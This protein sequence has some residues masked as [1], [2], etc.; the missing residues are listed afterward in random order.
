MVMAVSVSVS[1][2]MSARQDGADQKSQHDRTRESEPLRLHGFLPRRA[3]PG[4][5]AWPEK[6]DLELL[7]PVLFVIAES[8]PT[9]CV[10]CWF[11]R[12]L[13]KMRAFVAALITPAG[14]EVSSN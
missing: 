12:G 8:M 1:M 3:L 10:G 6:S 5:T 11:S 2:T 14:G 13:G 4:G 9:T 7:V